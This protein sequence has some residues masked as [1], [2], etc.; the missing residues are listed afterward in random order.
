MGVRVNSDAAA[1]LLLLLP[2]K[3]FQLFLNPLHSRILLLGLEV[4]VVGPEPRVV[5]LVRVVQVKLVEA[6]GTL[7]SESGRVK[8]VRANLLKT[9]Y[10]FVM[11]MDFTETCSKSL[12]IEPG[13]DPSIYTVRDH[14]SASM[15]VS[16]RRVNTGGL[17]S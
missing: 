11:L 9:I 4:L 3:S 10:N 5:R 6:Q 1:L 16:R 15:I 12:E 13:P 7:M 14:F 8:I 2:Q 17:L